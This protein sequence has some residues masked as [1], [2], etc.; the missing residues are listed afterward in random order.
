MKEI[1]LILNIIVYSS[2]FCAFFYNLTDHNSKS[3]IEKILLFFS[4]IWSLFV[5]FF[6]VHNYH[7]M[8]TYPM[9][10]RDIFLVTTTNILFFVYISYKL[11]CEKCKINL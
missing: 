6:L 10:K 1:S 7:D 2:L 5:G 9:N 3:K 11:I 4:M 8:I